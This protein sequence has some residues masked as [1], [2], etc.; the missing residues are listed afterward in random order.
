M[1]TPPEAALAIARRALLP[2]AL[3]LLVGCAATVPREHSTALTPDEVQATR[4][5]QWA[6]LSVA[7]HDGQSGFA[8]L[9]SGQDAFLLRSLLSEQAEHQLDIQTYFFMGDDLT[10]RFLLRCLLEAAERGVRV[11]LLLDDLGAAGHDERLAALDSHP[12]IQVRVYNALALGRASLATRLLASL[13]YAARQHRRMHNKLWIADGAVAIVGGRNLGDE[14]F[15]AS[16]PRNFTDLDLMALGPVVPALSRSF[17]LYWN[18]G[19]AQPI[20][21]YRRVAPGAWHSLA[22]SLDQWLAAQADDPYLATLRRRYAHGSQAGVVERLHWGEGVAL[23]DPPGKLA[24]S[25]RPPLS[26]TLG[27]ALLA[28]APVPEDRLTLISAYFIPGETVTEWLAAQA[29]VGIEVR[30]VTNALEATDAPF[31]HGAYQRYR[32][33]LLAG[34][35]A[36]H[37]LRSGQ[38]VLTDTATGPGA[39][40]SALHIKALAIDERWLFVGSANADPRSVW[41]NSEVGLLVNSESLAAEFRDLVDLGVSPRLSYRVGRTAADRL[42]WETV[43]AGEPRRLAREPGD[44]WRRFMAWLGRVLPLDPWL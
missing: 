13:P 22:T 32:P 17:D 21:R 28:Q 44:P 37:E 15:S 16:E 10:T 9:A 1:T 41:W 8:L 11:R 26:R 24:W 33:A 39:S 3:V 40:A 43:V 5:G 27:G 19:L 29:E 7:P 20:A 4:L 38:S 42:H 14:Y 6:A 18:H 2:L 31:V 25:G 30:V 36:L 23:W 34:G 12:R 35:V